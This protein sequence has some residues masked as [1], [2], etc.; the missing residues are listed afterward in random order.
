MPKAKSNLPQ[1]IVSALTSLP[2]TIDGGM[3][4]RAFQIFT[5][6]PAGCGLWRIDEGHSHQ[7]HLCDGEWSLVDFNN[8]EIEVGEVVLSLLNNGAHIG[9]IALNKVGR[10]NCPHG[11]HHH[12]WLSPLNRRGLHLSDGRY[13]GF[14]L[15]AMILGRVIGLIDPRAAVEH[16]YETAKAAAQRPQK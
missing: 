5:H 8:R 11:E 6:V 3:E 10:V 1:E 4:C 14:H 7:P 16:M 15:K 13:C 9:Q 2:K 12:Y